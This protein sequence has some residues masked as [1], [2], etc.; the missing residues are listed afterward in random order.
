MAQKQIFLHD[1]TMSSTP[2]AEYDIVPLKPTD[3]IE[4]LSSVGYNLPETVA[5]ISRHG[6]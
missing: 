2:P 5:K 3:L 1:E 6:T 4:S